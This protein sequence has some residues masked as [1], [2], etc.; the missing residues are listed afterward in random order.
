MQPGADI[1]QQVQQMLQQQ[2]QQQQQ[3]KEMPGTLYRLQQP[4]SMFVSLALDNAGIGEGLF[5]YAKYAARVR[6]W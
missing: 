4:A 6:H 1:K 5:V 3:Q 2:Q